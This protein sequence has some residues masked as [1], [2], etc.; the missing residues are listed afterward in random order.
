MKTIK[1]FVPVFLA[2][3]TIAVVF[4]SPVFAQ[5]TTPPTET[6]EVVVVD[7]PV[8]DWEKI[9]SA[10]E[11]LLTAFLIPSIA[12]A[13]RWMY[14]KGNLEYSK[15][16]ETQKENFRLFLRTAIYAAEQMNLSGKIGD[17]LD[18]VVKLAETWL[19][20]RRLKI[21]LDEIRAE[22]EAIV[23]REFNMSKFLAPKSQ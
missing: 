21:G 20:Q 7:P 3:I 15:L 12:F 10:L 17:K 18:Y 19:A 8:F 2:V 5:D 6:G 1:K 13:A 23:A 16:T 22:I 14:A 11:D 9:S 4:V